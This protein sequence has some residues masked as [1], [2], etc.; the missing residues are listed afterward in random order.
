MAAKTRK[1]LNVKR[2][3]RVNPVITLARERARIQDET[4]EEVK[5]MAGLPV[6]NPAD[7]TIRKSVTDLISD[8]VS[9]SDTSM[10][11][12]SSINEVI[13]A[14]YRSNKVI[15]KFEERGGI[16][17]IA[18][19]GHVKTTILSRLSGLEGVMLCSDLTSKGLVA[20]RDAINNGKVHC[21]AF[22]D[23][24]KL[25]ERNQDTAENV[26]GNLRALVAEG[27][28]SA[29]FEEQESNPM[30]RRARALVLG[31]ATPSF[32]S[33]KIAK[34]RND[35]MSRR[36]LFCHYSLADPSVLLKAAFD[37]TPIE[38]ADA[39]I[40]MP[41]TTVLQVDKLEP[42]EVT[43]L[44][45]VLAWQLDT[46]P[47]HLIKKMLTVLKWKYERI[48][49]DPHEPYRILWDFGKCLKNAEV[50]VLMGSARE[51]EDIA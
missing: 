33:K 26:V 9:D 25:Y 29:A 28:T 19:P 42:I 46:I 4:Q 40:S 11:H 34:W 16:L 32:F 38:L 48:D 31:A 23:M 50:R 36:F 39:F 24:Q 49:G 22:L 7:I 15:S 30:I 20:A 27:F 45:R 43:F 14:A 6:M 41:T 8:V 3:A 51:G 35:G 1:T 10:V 5:M 17:F 12:I 18:P 44:E 47:I 21:F 37:D 2:K 13:H